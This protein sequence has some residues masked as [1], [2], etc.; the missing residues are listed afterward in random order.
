MYANIRVGQI[1]QLWYAAKKR[2]VCKYH[3][4]HCRVL[5]I[6][7]RGAGGPRNVLV[8]LREGVKLVVPQGNLKLN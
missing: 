7:R 3:A 2:S 6:A 4:R 5:I 8:M 1:A